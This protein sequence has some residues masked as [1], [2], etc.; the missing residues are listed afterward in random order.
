MSETSEPRKF[1]TTE[2]ANQALP[3]VKAIVQD[4]V[5]EYQEVV[6]RRNLLQKIRRQR[7]KASRPA[8]VAYSEELQEVEQEL[9]KKIGV[10]QEYVEELTHLG[11]ELKDFVKGLVDFPAMMDGREVYLCWHLGEDDVSHWH[12]LDAGFQGRQSLF[13]GTAGTAAKDTTHETN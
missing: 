2:E 8:N 5:R 10:L 6:D 3:L 12:E 9:Q 13:A 1:F 4:I 7:S 11:I